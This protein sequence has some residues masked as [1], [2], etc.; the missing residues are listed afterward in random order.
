MGSVSFHS[1]FISLNILII[2]CVEVINDYCH[3]ISNN[4]LDNQTMFAMSTTKV[5]PKSFNHRN[6]TTTKKGAEK[7]VFSSVNRSKS[8]R[9]VI[10]SSTMDSVVHLFF[11]KG[12]LKVKRSFVYEGSFKL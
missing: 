12:V 9:C 7:F 10:K 2:E 11:E 6:Y 1:T 3:T 8:Y 5:E 4:Q